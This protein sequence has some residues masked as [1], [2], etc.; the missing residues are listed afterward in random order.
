M[1]IA[2]IFVGGWLTSCEES[3]NEVELQPELEKEARTFSKQD[4]MDMA[5][6]MVYFA[7]KG[8]EMKAEGITRAAITWR[9]EYGSNR[10]FPETD[11]ETYTEGD[12]EP[13]HL[14]IDDGT[15]SAGRT[16]EECKSF[17]G[18]FKTISLGNWL[19]DNFGDC[20]CVETRTEV[21]DDGSWDVFGESCYTKHSRQ[22]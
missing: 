10:L 18:A 8:D 19:D 6:T 20:D 16:W 1:L 7:P 4:F 2:L 22:R 14:R 17:S 15:D 12:G 21:Q 5:E 3:V 11:L 13:I 9:F